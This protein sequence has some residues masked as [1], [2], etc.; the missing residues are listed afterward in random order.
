MEGAAGLF[1]VHVYTTN[2]RFVVPLRC[3]VL[4]V[5]LV[6][7]LPVTCTVIAFPC[8]KCP[9]AVGFTQDLIVRD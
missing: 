1:S 5:K 8:Q 4:A 3:K 9:W 2:V 6:T 7:F